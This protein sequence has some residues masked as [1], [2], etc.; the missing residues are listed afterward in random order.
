[1]PFGAG[2][3]YAA[4]RAVVVGAGAIALFTDD[5]T[6]W[7]VRAEPREGLDTFRDS[8]AG[9]DIELHVHASYLVN[10]ATPDPEVARR[11][12]MRLIHELEIARSYGARTLNVH[13]GS[14]KGSGVDVGIARAGV[15]LA[16]VLAARPADVVEPRLVLEDSAG[17]GA[18]VGVTV[19]ELAAILEAAQARGADPARLGVCLDTAHLWSAGH[20]LDDPDS[21]DALLAR[22]DALLGA[23]ALMLVHAN[24]SRARAGSRTDRHEHLGAGAIG[25]VGLGHLL[26]HPRL[27]S[28]PMILET[29]GMQAGWDAV[30]MAR[31]RELLARQPLTPLMPEGLA[32]GT[33]LARTAY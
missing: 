3:G 17:Q 18:A 30:N 19:E 22:A 13:V 21:I 20:A 5:P 15:A 2:L 26:S 10:L 25:A 23:Q 9:S 6:G 31:V 11:S 16:A 14:H 4:E 29:P 12:V 24:D 1:M 8:L 27:E 33:M 32:H 7:T 28:V